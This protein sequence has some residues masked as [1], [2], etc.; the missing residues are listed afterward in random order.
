LRTPTSP[1]C[2]F[3]VTIDISKRLSRRFERILQNQVVERGLRRGLV[4][5]SRRP[6][7][8]CVSVGRREQPHSGGFG[9][10][11]LEEAIQAIHDEE[12]WKLRPID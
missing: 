8:D 4:Q 9:I 1:I 6:D 12:D 5:S 11:T 10:N 7:G 3:A 2:H